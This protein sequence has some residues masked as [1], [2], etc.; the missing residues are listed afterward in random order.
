MNPH[1]WHDHPTPRSVDPSEITVTVTVQY[2]DRTV[3]TVRRGDSG[4]P[5]WAPKEV[6]R[7]GEG[8]LGEAVT[9]LAAVTGDT[10]APKKVTV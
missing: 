1:P 10:D 9:M 6:R 5:T 3:T 4:N 8:A 7:A 2:G